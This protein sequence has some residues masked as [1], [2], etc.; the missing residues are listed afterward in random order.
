MHHKIFIRGFLGLL[1]C[2]PLGCGEKIEPG[3]TAGMPPPVVK[4][5][6]ATAQLSS[7][8]LVYEAVGTVRARTTSTLASKLL[9][10]V[11]QVRVQEGDRV[12]ARD[13]LLV[14]DGRQVT[15]Q[16][17]Q[18]EAVMAEAAKAEAAAVS[19]REAA[20]AGADLARATYNR[21]L[22]LMEDES[23]SRQEFE[24]IEARH[25]QAQAAV[26]QA[27][28]MV[29]GASQRVR[30]AQAAVAAAR[31][32]Q[33]DVKISAPYNG[34]ITAR[35][36]EPGDLAA[37]GTPLLAL[38]KTGAYRVEMVLPETHL[39]S[40]RLDQKLAVHIP[41]LHGP[42]VEGTV[43]TV[44]PAADHQSRSFMVKVDLPDNPALRSGMFARVEIPLVQAG[45]LVIPSSAVVS[46]G[47]LTG[48]FVLDA[49][50]IAR[51]RLIRIG[52]TLGDS[53]EVLS[54]LTAGVRFVVKPSPKLVDGVRVEVG[55]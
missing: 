42:A 14:L 9:G 38:H 21:Y 6:V 7:R 39:R 44:F 4:A 52:R 5:A 22:R 28:A 43:V 24:E 51:F 27:D 16:L 11:K 1:L 2:L 49:D 18:A 48:I 37:P 19:A 32:T 55:P 40:V 47:Q 20:A 31:V 41:A 17:H 15:S 8:P 10:T 36:V 34:I 46:Q 35:M 53:V 26:A 54:G 29:S 33:N 3:T 13:I 25:R 50:R 12:K 45:M 30:Q 23:A